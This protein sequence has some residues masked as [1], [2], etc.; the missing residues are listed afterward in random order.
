MLKFLARQGAVFALEFNFNS[1]RAKSILAGKKHSRSEG[2]WLAKHI[3]HKHPHLD[4]VVFF[5]SG[6]VWIDDHTPSPG[7]SVEGVGQGRRRWV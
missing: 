1:L 3:A 6:M 2:V 7:A 4:G 5:S